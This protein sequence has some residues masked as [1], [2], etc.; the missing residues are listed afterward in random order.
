[1]LLCHAFAYDGGSLGDNILLGESVLALCFAPGIETALER[2]Q[3]V[4]RSYV[5]VL[6][7]AR[8]DELQLRLDSMELFSKSDTRSKYVWG[9]AN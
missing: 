8:H 3:A 2:H 4:F 5:L 7:H 9:T 1:M 6:L